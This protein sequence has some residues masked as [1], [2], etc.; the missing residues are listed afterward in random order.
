MIYK[1]NC[2]IQLC[3][4]VSIGNKSTQIMVGWHKMG[5]FITGFNG[6]DNIGYV[7]S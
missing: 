5:G 1:L 4:C 7:F 3:M 2:R 6:F